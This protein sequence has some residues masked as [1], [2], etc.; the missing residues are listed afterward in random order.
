M[1][2]ASA[3]MGSMAFGEVVAQILRD[4]RGSRERQDDSEDER[5]ARHAWL[6]SLAASRRRGEQF[7]KLACPIR[8]I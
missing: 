2:K 7:V 8:T 3:L 6:R 1:I 4:D 5:L